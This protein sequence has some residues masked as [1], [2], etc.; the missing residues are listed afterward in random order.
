MHCGQLTLFD[1][2][3][4]PRLTGTQTATITSFCGLRGKSGSTS[5]SHREKTG[6]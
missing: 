2:R 5:L 1:N 6:K 4:L 3:R